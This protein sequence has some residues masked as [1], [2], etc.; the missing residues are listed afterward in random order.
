VTAVTTNTGGSSLYN[1]CWL[2]IQVRL[3]ADYS[4]PHPSSDSVT[5]EGGWWKIRYSMGGSASSYS[6]DLTTWQVSIR[7]SP[8]H[9]VP[10]Q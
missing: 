9:L 1:G 8:V 2:T 5:S 3:P 6:T 4:A 10:V 7:G